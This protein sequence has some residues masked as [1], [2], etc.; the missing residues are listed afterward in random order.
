MKNFW[1]KIV[2]GVGLVSLTS[3]AFA[4]NVQT[5]RPAIGPNGTF[6]LLGSEAVAPRSFAFG[7][8]GNYPKSPLELRDSVTG[9]RIQ[10]LVK[11][12]LTSDIVGEFGILPRWSIGFDAPGTYISHNGTTG[13]LATTNNYQFGDLSIY[14]RITLV[15]PNAQPVGVAVIPYVE[16]P[17]GSQKNFTGDSG[18]NIG[19][20]VAVDKNFGRFY[21]VGNVGFRGHTKNET[22]AVSGSTDTLELG[23]EVTYGVGGSYD[24]IPNRLQIIGEVAGSTV[25]KQFA[26]HANASPAEA[27]AG[28]R[29]F[30]KDKSI[31]L[32]A[33]GG[34]GLGRGYGAPTYRVFTGLSFN[35]PSGNRE[36]VRRKPEIGDIKTII[37]QGVHFDTARHALTA[38]AKHI[39][40]MNLG[41]IVSNPQ[42]SLRIDGHA[43]ARGGR[44]YNY[45][46]SERRAAAVRDYFSA[47]SVP[48]S[49]LHVEGFGKDVPVAPNTG[50]ANWA[51]NRRV[52]IHLY[53][54]DVE[55]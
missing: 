29:A 9:N 32:V 22:T 17:T 37:L 3:S 19:A 11:Y 34:A 15:D 41:E 4:L 13:T 46:L 40:D 33:G 28:I 47:K 43:D 31:A 8:F 23:H 44:A 54:N 20:K 5:F 6:R 26:Q 12:S 21:L 51:R 53:R 48:T 14:S 30:F 7:V 52:V 2:V 42:L 18:T 10:S 36:V 24:A 27:T 55:K 45:A 16:T 50:P 35:L 1:M 39:L 49:R 25:L 38:D